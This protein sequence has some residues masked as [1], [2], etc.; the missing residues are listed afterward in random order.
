MYKTK[1]IFGI[2]IKERL[3]DATPMQTLFTKY[4]CNIKTRLGLHD[5]DENICSGSGIVLLELIGNPEDI[6]N[7]EKEAQ[8]VSGV[9]IQKMVF[10]G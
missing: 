5:A 4:G 2:Y 8:V 1:T 7:F 10:N 6:A 9:E 3:K